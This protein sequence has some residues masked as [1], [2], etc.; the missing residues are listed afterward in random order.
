MCKK[1][2]SCTHLYIVNFVSLPVIIVS[3]KM[4]D[5][6]YIEDYKDIFGTNVCV[7]RTLL[8]APGGCSLFFFFTQRLKL[9]FFLSQ[10]LRCISLYVVMRL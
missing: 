7:R 8:A 3:K 2:T 10:V 9:L 6:L 4:G 5:L 1:T